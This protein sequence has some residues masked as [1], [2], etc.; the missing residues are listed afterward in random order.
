V[1]GGAARW[2]R[3]RVPLTTERTLH[4]LALATRDLCATPAETLKPADIVKLTMILTA[5]YDHA[6]RAEQ[7]LDRA[8]PHS[9]SAEIVRLSDHRA[10]GVSSAKPDEAEGEPS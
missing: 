6:K 8:G 5:L 9:A 1:S 7:A 2:L 4:V 3:D 10:P